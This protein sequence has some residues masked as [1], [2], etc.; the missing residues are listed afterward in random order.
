MKS[1]QFQVFCFAVIAI[2]S[3]VVSAQE[4]VGGNGSL[5]G[6]G[7]GPG[8]GG[9]GPGSGGSGPS[10]G[11]PSPTPVTCAIIVN[12]S[13]ADFYGAFPPRN[14]CTLT[15]CFSEE[16]CTNG[17][18]AILVDAGGT[19]AEWWIKKQ[20]VPSAPPSGG[21]GKWSELRLETCF[22]Q[23]VC[24]YEC[25]FVVAKGFVCKNRTLTR[26][27]ISTVSKQYDECEIP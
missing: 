18:P 23:I 10:G 17:E 26:I 25:F 8:G 3:T 2:L 20:S 13:C 7:S 4:I 1:F 21:K 14:D 24:E 11:G 6:G 19:S 22:Y 16:F 5:G 15:A 27:N 12:K 9:S